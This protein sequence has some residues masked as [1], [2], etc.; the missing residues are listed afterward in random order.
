MTAGSPNRE[1]EVR[2]IHGCSAA[3]ALLF[4]V[5]N[6]LPACSGIK[7]YQNTSDKNLH[8][9]TE[10]DFE[11]WFPRVRTAVD[12]HRVWE[13]CTVDYQGTV[14][15]TQPKMDI[16]I[17]TDNWSYLVFVFNTPSLFPNRSGTIT[18]ETLVKPLPNYRY[19]AAVSYQNDMY[20]VKIR[21]IPPNRSAGRELDRVGLDAC[22]SFS[23]RK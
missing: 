21:E 8:V 1:P 10:A 16:G 12:I 3:F 19:E 14:Q 9:Q 7:T 23:T 18:Y 5:V 4:C 17:P 13:G 15:L 20:H 11:S 22:R 2:R 6:L